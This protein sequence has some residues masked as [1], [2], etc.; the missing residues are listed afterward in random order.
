[1]GIENEKPQ[2]NALNYV[3][4]KSWDYQ[5]SGDNQIKIRVC[6]YCANSNFKFYMNVSG[7]KQDSLW[8]CKV[9]SEAGNLTKL[10]IAQGDRIEGVMS[11]QDAN[12]NTR[13]PEA[14]P[15]VALAH[16]L[17]MDDADALDYLVG[18]R[19]F[20]V[21]VIEQYKLGLEVH[22][23]DK[24]IVIPYFQKGNCVFVKYRSLPPAE[25]K[26]RSLAG[27]EAP[28]FNEDA[29]TSD[30]E[31][32]ILVEGET[33]TL[34]CL[35]QG[36]DKVV[37]I[38]GANVKKAV[39]IKRLNDAA[40]KKIYILYDNDKVGQKAAKEMAKRIG[41]AKVYNILLPDFK[42]V[43]DTD[44][45][46]INEWFRAGHSIEEFETL[47]AQSTRFDV[48]GVTSLGL[49]LDELQADIE[50]RGLEPTLITPWESLNK[51]LGGMEWGDLVGVI[52]EGKCGKSTLCLN[53]LDYYS[54]IGISSMFYCLEMPPKRLARKWC[55]YVTETDDT[56][57]ASKICVATIK[58]AKAIA[59]KRSGDLLFAYSRGG[60]KEEVFDTIRQAVSLYGVKVVCFDNLQLL[61]RSIE[62]SAQE[63][64][65]LTKS[66]K[67]LAMELGI[68]IILVVQPNRVKDGEI[69]AARNAMGSSAIE[70]DVDSMIVLHRKRIAQIKDAEF[71][72]FMDTDA[73]FEPNMWVKVDLNRYGPGGITTLLME[74]HISRVREFNTEELNLLPKQNMGGIATES[75]AV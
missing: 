22:G 56:P 27:R 3:L 73:T 35:S 71:M 74:G 60:N 31:D 24:W 11:M 37:G 66:F 41:L 53:W 61:C 21:S 54:A 25:K 63:T 34:S 32:V 67:D 17:L 75:I 38:P 30:M 28:L 2:S 18:T 48:D 69:V 26:F 45:K 59:A 49:A 50:E 33:S 43:D 72:G 51:K 20:A 12:A 47:K 7:T 58:K 5:E 4:S 8:D 62:H 52:A 70:K 19:G 68:L 40:P 23:Q 9:C 14:I 64:S 44:G 65:I 42:T 36:I 6:P 29:I 1:M 16:K 10:M 57:G 55:S 46:D 39:W 15:N 13:Q